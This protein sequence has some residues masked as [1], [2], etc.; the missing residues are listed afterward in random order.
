LKVY[1]LPKEAVITATSLILYHEL[2]HPS[3]GCP[4]GLHNRL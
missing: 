1:P 2:N 3:S 4:S